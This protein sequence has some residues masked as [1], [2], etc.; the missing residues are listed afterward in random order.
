MDYIKILVGLGI[1]DK[2][3]SGNHF[4]EVDRWMVKIE[5]LL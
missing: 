3:F 2:L 4:D 5:D 1:Y